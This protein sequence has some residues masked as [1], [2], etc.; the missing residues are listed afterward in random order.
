MP[1]STDKI[2]ARLL[3]IISFSVTALVITLF[4]FA[5]SG[6]VLHAPHNF[7]QNVLFINITFL[8][9]TYFC[10]GLIIYLFYKKQY[11][12]ARLISGSTIVSLLFIQLIKNWF[13]D[14]GIQIF[15]EDEQYLFNTN[16]R[17]NQFVS[18][19]TA[20]AFSLVTIFA[21]HFKNGLQRFCLIPIAFLVGWS[22]IYLGHHSLPDLFAGAFIGILSG[23]S[24]YYCFLNFIKLIKPVLLTAT[25]F[26][27]RQTPTNAYAIE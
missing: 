27:E 1:L 25:K 17:T 19:H 21:L 2:N 6:L 10:F 18:S 23:S 20:L 15:F 5:P 12:I 9:S 13:T 14:S 16:E 24:V 8:G 26:T 11:A 22:R 7:W 4:K 3:F